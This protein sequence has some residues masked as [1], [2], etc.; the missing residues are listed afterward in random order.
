M[1]ILKKKR[2]Q[3]TVAKSGKAESGITIFHYITISSP[4]CLN[5]KPVFLREQQ[6]ETICKVYVTEPS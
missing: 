5:H 2:G 3:E 4:V 6:V 1:F